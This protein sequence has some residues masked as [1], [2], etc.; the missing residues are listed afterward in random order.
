VAGPDEE[1]LELGR[2][3]G[4]R[5]L[6]PAVLALLAAVV[7][8]VVLADQHDTRHHPPE[9]HRPAPVT[10]AAPT[11]VRGALE[12]TGTRCPADAHCSVWSEVPAAAVRAV[13][14][15]FPGAR[16]GSVITELAYRSGHYYA[17]LLAR[18]IVA[19]AD[20]STIV[21]D[22]RTAADATGPITLALRVDQPGYAVSVQVAGDEHDL[23]ALRL[24]RDPRLVTLE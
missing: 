24:A 8:G 2:R 7:A 18:R 9:A 23:S 20:G 6:G 16:I 21:V 3:R 5:W 1:I 4:R 12:I 15:A 11:P 22:V 19:H 10:F 14:A 13:R 17:D